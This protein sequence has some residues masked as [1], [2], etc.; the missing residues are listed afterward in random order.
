[1]LYLIVLIG[2]LFFAGVA[3]TVGE[4]LWNNTL[5]L[6]SVMLGGL[7]AVVAGVPLGNWVIVQADADPSY[8]WYFVFGGMWITFAL[9]VTLIRLA[10]DRLSPVRMKFIPLLDKITG[11]LMGLFVAVML[12]SFAAYTL[13]RVPIK[14]GEWDLATASDTQKS[15][16]TWARAPFLNVVNTFAKTE[17]IK[18]P[19][20]AH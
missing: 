18:T 7:L 17:G 3:M 14:A 20:I 13:E 12:T 19:F 1:M 10:T 16:L 4:G 6:F 11:P 9:S 8:A 5:L 2:F 15:L